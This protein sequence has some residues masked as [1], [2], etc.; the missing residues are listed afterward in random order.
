MI[1]LRT[2]FSIVSATA[3]SLPLIPSGNRLDRIRDA[4][5]HNQFKQ[6]H[7]VERRNLPWCVCLNVG[8]DQMPHVSFVRLQVDGFATRLAD[9][10]AQIQVT[11]HI[12]S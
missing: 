11:L 10:F 4:R 3:V 8:V 5:V 2:L 6:W 9:N 12:S 7:V 1:L